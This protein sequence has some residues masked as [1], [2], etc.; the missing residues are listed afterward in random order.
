MR[1]VLPWFEPGRLSDRP[2]GV[3][4]LRGGA[5]RPQ[6]PLSAILC[7]HEDGARPRRLFAGG[8]AGVGIGHGQGRKG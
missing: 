3:A 6:S 1:K 5:D 7:Q 2:P 4:G 8:A